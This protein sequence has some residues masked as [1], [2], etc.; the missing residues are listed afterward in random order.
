MT[1][2]A[3]ARSRR[4]TNMTN[5][6]I[7]P[8]RS[9]LALLGF[10][11]ALI[12][13]RGAWACETHANEAWTKAAHVLNFVKFVEWPNELPNTIE[14]CFSGADDVRNSLASAVVG[15][16][17]GA[18]SIVVRELTR[19]EAH[20]CHV[21]YLGSSGERNAAAKVAELPALTIGDAEDFTRRGGVIRLYKEHDRV[22]F[23][24]N[25]AN[26]RRSGLQVSSNLLRLAAS[27]EHEE[28]A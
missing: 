4:S 5:L 18:R 20:E 2:L 25:I 6:E 28:G 23:S 7:Q 16:S 27:V 19:E 1:R 9:T 13:A 15:K 11:T 26:A 3:Y 14:I 21:L 8:S 17:V 10:I 22:Q 12:C 24:I